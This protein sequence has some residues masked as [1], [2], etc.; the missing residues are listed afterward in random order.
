MIEQFL[1]K[2]DILA[3]LRPGHGKGLNFQL[4]VL[5]E[6]RVGNYASYASVFSE[7]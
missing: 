5:L 4:L 7:L 2:K 6:K 3:V 1:E